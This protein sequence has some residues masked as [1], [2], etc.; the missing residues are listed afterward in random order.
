[1]EKQMEES[2]VKSHSQISQFDNNSCPFGRN[3]IEKSF[4]EEIVL[5]MSM[6]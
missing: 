6:S 3:D 4:P 5:K 2:K 1:M